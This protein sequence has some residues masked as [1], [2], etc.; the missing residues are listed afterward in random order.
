MSNTSNNSSI[1]N[2]TDTR[3]MAA[4][5]SEADCHHFCGLS[6]EAKVALIHGLCQVETGSLWSGQESSTYSF[7]LNEGDY[8]GED[9]EEIPGEGETE[10]RQPAEREKLIMKSSRGSPVRGLNP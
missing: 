1:S 6:K 10:E 3:Q 2:K 9:S 8:T 4:Q 7:S 5:M